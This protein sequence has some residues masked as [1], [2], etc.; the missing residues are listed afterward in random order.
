[1]ARLN[2]LYRE[3][4]AAAL[5][6]A[7]L[8]GWAGDNEPHWL[9]V[10]RLVTLVDHADHY[11][12]VSRSDKWMQSHLR[13]DG[14]WPMPD[15]AVML[16]TFH[17]GAGYWGL[18]HAAAHGFKPHA[19]VASLNSQAYAGRTIMSWY[20]RARNANVAQT[21]G[22]PNIDVARNLKQ[23]IRALRNKDC[24]LGVIDVPAD[25]AKAS[26][27]L[28]LLG[29]HASVPRGLM[30][31]A[32]DHQ[33][34]VVLYLTGLNTRTGQRFL[35][36][37]QLGVYSDVEALAHAAFLELEKAIAEDPPAWHFW[38]ISERFFG[39]V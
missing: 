11:L 16:M 28:T 23:V 18:R 30:R 15:L 32:V 2:W 29:M 36:I 22:S 6:Q 7:R 20:A 9:W 21:L 3:Q 5:Q 37:K 19:L 35:R 12:G 8:R 26:M 10:R 4:C 25:E 27:D 39:P 24:L 1:L 17:W 14:A 13:V 33:V 38:A 34:P 31:L